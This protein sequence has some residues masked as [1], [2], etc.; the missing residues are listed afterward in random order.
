MTTTP[1]TPTPPTPTLTIDPLDQQADYAY[2]LHQVR[3]LKYDPN[4]TPSQKAELLHRAIAQQIRSF[5]R[6]ERD[7]V[8]RYRRLS[9][10]SKDLQVA[11]E[12]LNN[13]LSRELRKVKAQDAELRDT[14]ATLQLLEKDCKAK[15]EY[16]YSAEQ[17]NAVLREKNKEQRNS[18]RTWKQQL[19]AVKSELAV[20]DKN[21]DDLQQL[22]KRKGAL[23]DKYQQEIQQ[24]R[25][26]RQEWERQVDRASQRLE[27]K[28]EKMTTWLNGV[29]GGRR[30]D[31]ISLSA[32]TSSSKGSSSDLSDLGSS[33]MSKST[34]NPTSNGSDENLDGTFH[35][36]GSE[37]DSRLDYMGSAQQT[38]KPGDAMDCSSDSRGRKRP[39]STRGTTLDDEIKSLSDGLSALQLDTDLSLMEWE[40]INREEAYSP[41]SEY[42]LDFHQR[43]RKRRRSKRENE[44]CPQDDAE[45][46]DHPGQTTED[47][48][49]CGGSLPQ[50]E[51]EMLIVSDNK[52]VAD[53]T[54][55]SPYEPPEV[56]S[57]EHSTASHGTQPV[58]DLHE[59]TI[60]GSGKSSQVSIQ[61][62]PRP[63]LANG[64]IGY[65]KDPV[66]LPKS[67]PPSQP[68]PLS[69][70]PMKPRLISRIKPVL[71]IRVDPHLS[72][73]DESQ[74]LMDGDSQYDNTSP[75]AAT[76]P[77]G[78]EAETSDSAPSETDINSTE[79]KGEGEFQMG[80]RP[81]LALGGKWWLSLLMG[82]VLLVTTVFQRPTSSPKDP[83]ESWNKI[84]A[85][86]QDPFTKLQKN[87]EAR[88]SCV[89]ALKYEAFH[90]FD[91][92]FL[93]FG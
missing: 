60:V 37:I 91:K 53:E 7:H 74:S 84:N 57:S 56:I 34:T 8:D 66:W 68:L 25:A 41:I 51:K 17:A 10:E 82:V 19:E 35:T 55:G 27:D 14:K 18:I 73:L 78:S 15:E 44:P 13:K 36:T 87:P 89:R 40:P 47:F 20:R 80:M 48:R 52:D 24:Y 1:T 77:I 6:I 21:V 93:S 42:D 90:F 22:L 4:T 11:Y 16:I 29:S 43:P 67:F 23:V 49:Y 79:A 83:R 62:E 88:P 28:S 64:R 75:L 30:H 26:Q 61:Q 33:R 31:R 50:E 71:R 5:T 65:Y 2:F 85:M 86:V 3:Q 54:P 92:D 45:D 46:S 32:D 63:L 70:D 72:E 12:K 76:S 38:V 58:D 9:D 81:S 59:P 39:G 69:S